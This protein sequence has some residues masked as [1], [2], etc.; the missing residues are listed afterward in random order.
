MACLR[1]GVF[2]RGPAPR[3]PRGAPCVPGRGDGLLGRGTWVRLLPRI[4]F[5]PFSSASR[6][7]LFGPG[8]GEGGAGA[9]G[10]G[11]LEPPHEVPGLGERERILKGAEGIAAGE[12]IALWKSLVPWP[13]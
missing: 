1:C 7:A 8:V 12:S 9:E 11:F 5:S 4:V 3:A 6:F 13:L 10:F 2:P